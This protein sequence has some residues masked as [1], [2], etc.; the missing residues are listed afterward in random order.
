MQA[1]KITRGLTR[2]ETKAHDEVWCQ[3]NLKGVEI[4]GLMSLGSDE[5]T[6]TFSDSLST[7]HGHIIESFIQPY[8]SMTAER[9]STQL[10]DNQFKRACVKTLQEDSYETLQQAVWA[11]S[12]IVATPYV[13]IKVTNITQGNIASVIL[14]FIKAI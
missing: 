14:T 1:H 6:M 9:V 4:F 7:P 3:V 5:L 2:Q 8:V 12:N 11:L 10:N 13:A